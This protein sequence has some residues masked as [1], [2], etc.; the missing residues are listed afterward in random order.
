MNWLGTFAQ[1]ARYAGRL[2]WRAKA[3]SV[4]AVSTLALGIAGTTVM[5]AL[6]HGVLL[7]PLPVHEQDRLILAWKEVPTSGSARYPFGNTEIAAVAAAS[8]LLEQAAGVT[9]N[10]VARTVVTDGGTSGYV[11][12]ALVTGGFFDVLGVKPIAGRTL[13]RCRRQRRVGACR[14]H[15]QRALATTLWR[16][17]RHRRPSRLPR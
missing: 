13:V 8:R 15:Q 4:A 7:R 11:N 1:D 5:A 16:G 17:T 2:L 12:V 10:G 6:V 3:F 14:R 9:R